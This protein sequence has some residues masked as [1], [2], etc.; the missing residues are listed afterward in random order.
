MQQD[1]D[2]KVTVLMP[3]Y[4]GEKYL[5]EAIDSILNQTFTDFEFLI[6]DDGSTDNTAA[7]IKS[8][9]DTRISFIQNNSNKGLV[10]SLNRGL[11]FAKG[12]YIARI[13]C[14]DIAD[15]ERINKQTFYLETHPKIGIIGSCYLAFNTQS[16]NLRFGH[17]PNTDY[18]IRWTSLLNNPFAHPTIML[19]K[20]TLR[21][22]NLKYDKNFPFTEDYDLW[23]RLLKF[24]K[25]VNLSQTLILYRIREGETKIHREEMLR[26]HDVIA[27]RTI[28]STLPDFSISPEQVTAMRILLVTQDFD[29]RAELI[30]LKTL[31]NI[32]D[33]YLEMLQFF[34]KKD[35]KSLEKNQL[36]QQEIKKVLRLLLKFSKKYTSNNKFKKIWLSQIQALTKLFFI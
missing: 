20:D 3:V 10:Y 23:T 22:H 30:N 11:D 6:I 2:P 25:G 31:E 5:R 33:K 24:T 19:R 36:K 27:L 29:S 12:E 21:K 34:L 35:A 17:L 14:D 26:L 4:N 16:K 9:E 32:L 13:D 28:Q 18:K 7:L 1:K 8:Y 15:P